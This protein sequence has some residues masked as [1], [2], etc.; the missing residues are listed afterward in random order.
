MIAN[1]F[2][3]IPSPLP[4]EVVETL[5]RSEHIRIER[6][7]SRGQASPPDFWYDQDWHE[8]VVLLA[9]GARLAFADGAPPVDLTP[10]GWLDIPAHR[11]HRVDWTDPEQDTIWLAVHY[12]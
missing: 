6:I 11:Q 9:G 12:R 4:D 2:Q 3:Q 1:L 10:G 5:C 7:V 8:F